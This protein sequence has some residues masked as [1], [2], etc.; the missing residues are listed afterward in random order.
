MNILELLQKEEERQ[1]SY[2]NLIASENIASKRI[3]QAL[4]S[5][6]TNKYAE[7]YPK[8]RWYGGC[9]FADQIESY[10]IEKAKT[11][12][13]AESANLQPHS[14]SS[15]NIAAYLSLLKPGDKVLAMG[16]EHGGHLSHGAPFHLSGKFYNFV[17]YGVNRESEI[18]EHEEIESLLDQHPDTKL[19][20]AGASSYPRSIDFKALGECAKKRNLLFMVDIAHISG[21]VATGHHPDPLPWADVVTLSTHKTLRG[22]RGGMILSKAVHQKKIDRAVFP[23]TQGGPLEHVIAA[24][25]VMLEEALE[26]SFNN[27]IHEVIQAAQAL[28]FALSEINPQHY[29]I[30]TGGTDNHMVMVDVTGRKG[31][32]GLK[33]E[34]LLEAQGIY[35][36]KNFIPF[37][38][39]P[40]SI[41]SG[42]RLGTPTLVTQGARASDMPQVA[43]LIDAA[44]SEKTVQDKVKAFMTVL[45]DR[46]L[47]SLAPST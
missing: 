2:I 35:V 12:F 42:I 16:L 20:L 24:K 23:G 36:N 43:E 13:G 17:H 10:A 22:P 47:S 15:A 5:T 1:N 14:G 32:N 26:P 8:Q 9:E 39:L 31:L 40:V 6:L 34:Q 30:I 18:I 27:Y 3:L 28:A 4:G 37:D 38:P 25:A 21:L 11:L 44:L 19:L 33:A 29:R 7:G 41:T 45:K 46:S